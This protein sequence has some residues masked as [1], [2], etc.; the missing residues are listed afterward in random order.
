VV[1]PADHHDE[2]LIPQISAY[3]RTIDPS[4]VSFIRIDR[5]YFTKREEEA[6]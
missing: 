5:D 1:V 2:K 4:F 3:V 6:D